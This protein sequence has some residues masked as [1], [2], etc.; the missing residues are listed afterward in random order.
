MKAG[1]TLEDIIV[2][3]MAKVTKDTTSLGQFDGEKRFEI[4][5][6]HAKELK[7][8]IVELLMQ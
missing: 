6:K 7:K 8:E 1:T 5:K 2:L 3:S 4:Y